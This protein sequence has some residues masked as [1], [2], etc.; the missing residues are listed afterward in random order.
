MVP[1]LDFCFGNSLAYFCL[2]EELKRNGKADKR[3]A[4]E[5]TVWSYCSA[6]QDLVNCQWGACTSPEAGAPA[7]SCWHP[8]T[9]AVGQVAGDWS[10][11]GEAGQPEPKPP[12]QGK[13]GTAPMA[14]H[15]QRISQRNSRRA[16]GSLG[17][18]IKKRLLSPSPAGTRYW[19]GSPT[20]GEERRV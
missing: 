20:P 1:P 16:L 18:K 15:G 9:A 8:T 6:Q 14:R 13:V 7:C 10:E 19:R 5:S 3:L 2:P 4:G 11:W 17:Y 12:P